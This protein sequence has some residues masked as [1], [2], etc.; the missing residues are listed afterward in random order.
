[1]PELRYHHIGIPTDRDLPN[2]DYT[3]KYKMYASGYLESPYGVEWLKFDPDCPLPA[4]TPRIGGVK[5]PEV[6]RPGVFL[7]GEPPRLLH[8]PVSVR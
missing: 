1:M 2:K 6:Q 4:S 7:G 8:G 3:F 5:K